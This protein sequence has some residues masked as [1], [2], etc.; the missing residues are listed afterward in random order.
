MM[1]GQ[2][3]DAC[4]GCAPREFMLH[5]VER[6]ANLEAD[7]V[8]CMRRTHAHEKARKL[9]PAPIRWSWERQTMF[10]S[11]RIALG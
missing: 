11:R 7:C 8:E 6:R 3:I 1:L 5:P 9:Q 10:C 4:D 2:E